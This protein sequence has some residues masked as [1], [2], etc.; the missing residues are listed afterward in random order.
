MRH[1]NGIGSGQ[2]H[3]DITGISGCAVSVQFKYLPV[4]SGCNRCENLFVDISDDTAP[5]GFF[6]MAVVLS[7]SNPD[8]L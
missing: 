5:A 2:H 4:F 1:G 3:R 6:V 8:K 7:G